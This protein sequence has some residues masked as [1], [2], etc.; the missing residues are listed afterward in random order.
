MDKHLG[1]KNYTTNLFLTNY[2]E[3]RLSSVSCNSFSFSTTVISTQIIDTDWSR[4]I[5]GNRVVVDKNNVCIFVNAGTISFCIQNVYECQ[6]FRV[7]RG[8]RPASFIYVGPRFTN[9]NWLKKTNNL[10]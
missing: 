6:Q 4:L 5:G 7:F 2:A 8:P 1:G 3:F 9:T 10:Q